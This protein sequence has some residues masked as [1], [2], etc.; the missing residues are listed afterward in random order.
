[1]PIFCYIKYASFLFF[2]NINLNTKHLEIFTSDNGMSRGGGYT[3]GTEK[4]FGTNNPKFA[5]IFY[6]TT[7]KNQGEKF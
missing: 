7:F 4:L 3:R 6:I 2:S 5:C 1:M